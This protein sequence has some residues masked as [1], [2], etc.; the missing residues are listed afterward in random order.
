MVLKLKSDDCSSGTVVTRKGFGDASQ[1][2]WSNQ[3]TR[4][5]LSK[6]SGGVEGVMGREGFGQL[7]SPDTSLLAARLI[8]LIDLAEVREREHTTWL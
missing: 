6:N 3:E 8:Q 4:K 7:V 2:R 1:E 5:Q